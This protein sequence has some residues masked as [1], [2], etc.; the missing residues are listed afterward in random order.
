MEMA[1]LINRRNALFAN[2]EQAIFWP[3]VDIGFI[4]FVSRNGE[5]EGRLVLSAEEIW[6]RLVFT[7]R[8]VAT[9][10]F[11]WNL[12]ILAVYNIKGLPSAITVRNSKCELIYEGRLSFQKGFYLIFMIELINY[13]YTTIKKY[14]ILRAY[15][16]KLLS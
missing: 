16:S 14:Y 2:W 11:S 1:R 3:N 10:I 7:A 6:D 4:P 9:C 15:T 5:K 12:K 8:N 13:L